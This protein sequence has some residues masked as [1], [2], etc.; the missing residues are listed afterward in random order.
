M[1][2]WTR[3][4]LEVLPSGEITHFIDGEPVLRYAAPE[5]DLADAAPRGTTASIWL[6]RSTDR[7]PAELRAAGAK[8]EHETVAPGS[9]A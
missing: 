8:D 2:R 9:S 1:G 6:P 4:E 3:V 7:I 5:L